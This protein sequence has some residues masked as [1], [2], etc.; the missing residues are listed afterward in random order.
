[1]LVASYSVIIAASLI[2]ISSGKVVCK[3]TFLFQNPGKKK[4]RCEIKEASKAQQK[5]RH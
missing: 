1:M 2:N 3:N 4:K 5:Y